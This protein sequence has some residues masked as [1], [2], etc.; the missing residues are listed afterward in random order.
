MGC[1]RL[2]ALFAL[3]IAVST[4]L[5]AAPRE[6]RA[7][8]CQK[9]K[10]VEGCVVSVDIRRKDIKPEDR[11]DE[12]RAKGVSLADTPMALLLNSQVYATTKIKVPRAGVVI[13]NASL[14]LR[15]V[16]NPAASTFGGRGTVAC[17]LVSKNKGGAI[18]GLPADMFGSVD[19]KAGLEYATL[20]VTTGFD[21]DKSDKGAINI[22]LSCGVAGGLS[23]SD[24]RF[25]EVHAPSINAA[26]YSASY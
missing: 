18:M 22:V 3:T 6:A 26:Y 1:I 17:T 4:L 5:G 7:T 8:V 19:W 15:A 12:A 24:A 2:T 23:G 20:A 10:P 11:K 13:V 25:L 14:Y 9:L 21:V 16:E